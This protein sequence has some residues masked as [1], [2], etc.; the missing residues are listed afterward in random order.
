MAMRRPTGF[1]PGQYWRASASLTMA[2]SGACWSSAGREEPAVPQRH[3]DRFEVARADL[4][5]VRVVRERGLA[6]APFDRDRARSAS[7]LERHGRREAGRFDAK[8]LRESI[9]HA[10]VELGAPRVLTISI[11]R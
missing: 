10:V 8:F 7:P 11:E 6:R 5:M 2:T 3:A 9:E 1:S 4:A